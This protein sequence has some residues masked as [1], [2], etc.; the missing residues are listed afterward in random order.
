[1]T[2]DTTYVAI[3]PFFHAWVRLMENHTRVMEAR[4]PRLGSANILIVSAPTDPGIPALAHANS[5]GNTRLLCFS[6]RMERVALRYFRRHRIRNASTVIA[7]FFSIPSGDGLLDSI[8]ANCFFDLCDAEETR[9][10]LETM[11]RALKPGGRL[12]SVHMGKPTR[13]AGHAWAW[14]SRGFPGLSPGFRPI[15]LVPSVRDRGFELVQDRTPRRFGF[16]LSYIVAE[17]RKDPNDRLQGA[18][19]LPQ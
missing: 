18:P 13:S 15:D 9:A 4:D 19:T 1:M 2:I 5:T 16:P 17:K 8:Y 12:H 6:D 11:W 7:P 14:L 3:S 10:V